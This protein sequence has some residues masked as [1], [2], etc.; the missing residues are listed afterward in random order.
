MMP[1]LLLSA[2]GFVIAGWL[3]LLPARVHTP[4]GHSYRRVYAAHV[5]HLHWQHRETVLLL[6][7][8]MGFSCH[9]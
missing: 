4:A 7:G 1:L 3:L 8:P 2:S 9:L 5:M 6:C